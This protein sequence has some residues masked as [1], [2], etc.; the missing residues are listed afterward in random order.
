MKRLLIAAFALCAPLATYAGTYTYSTTGAEDLTHGTAYTWGIEGAGS[1]LETAYAAGQRVTSATIT[2]SSVYDWTAE[3][4][5]VLYVDLLNGTKSGIGTNDYNNYLTGGVDTYVGTNPFS[6]TATVNNDS[7]SV[8][9]Y[10]L[11]NATSTGSNPVSNF[12]Y[13]AA[14]QIGAYTDTDGGATTYN[15]VITLTGAELTTLNSYLATDESASGGDLGLGL[16]PD[17]HFYDSGISVAFTTGA[18]DNSLTVT[19]LGA[20]LVGLA[21]FSRRK[22]NALIG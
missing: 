19:M 8:T 12:S 3:T 10:A 14:T 6:T 15:L 1:T 2:I 22:K 11:S 17:C 5:D 13:S 18:S 9:G 4:K 16:G 21:A 20:S 7:A